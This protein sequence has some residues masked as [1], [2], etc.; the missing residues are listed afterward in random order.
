MNGEHKRVKK[1]EVTVNEKKTRVVPDDDIFICPRFEKSPYNSNETN[2]WGIILVPKHKDKDPHSFGFGFSLLFATHQ[3]SWCEPKM[4]LMV[5]GYPACEHKGL[6]ISSGKGRWVCEE[7]LEYNIC[8]SD[9]MSGSPV[10]LAHNGTETVIGI[11]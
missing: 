3:T 8:T 1:L 5:A 6:V 10:V 4:D 7:Q 11:Q 9:G 2:D